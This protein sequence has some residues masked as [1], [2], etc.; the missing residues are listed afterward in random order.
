MFY[1]D[2]SLIRTHSS[3]PT[4]EVLCILYYNVVQGSKETQGSDL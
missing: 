4:V 2:T 3:V 1:F